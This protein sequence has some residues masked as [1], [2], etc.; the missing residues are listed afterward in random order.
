MAKA[1][2]IDLRERI[3]AACEAGE[4]NAAVARRFMVSEAF[5]E[6]LKRRYRDTGSLAPRPHAGG[7]SLRLAPEEER[8][9]TAWQEQ[10]DRTLAELRAELDLPAHLSTLWHFLRRLGLTFKKTLLAAEQARD[11]V[12]VRRAA[13][14]QEREAWDP[15]RWVFL[16]ETGLTT[17]WVRRYGWGPRGQRVSRRAARSSRRSHPTARTSTPSNRCLPN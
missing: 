16:D 3:K 10:P 5:V 14:R 9:R 2:S 1:I 6:K 4:T 15:A 13:W 8:L 11:D 12:R 7:R 17:A